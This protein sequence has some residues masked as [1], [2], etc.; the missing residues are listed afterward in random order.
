VVEEAWRALEADKPLYIAGGFGGAA[1]AVA[2]LLDGKGVPAALREDTWRV[3]AHFAQTAAALRDNPWRVELGLPGSMDAMAE[4]IVRLGASKLGAGDAAAVDWNGLT[5]A[6][7]R[8]LFS[9]RD[10]VTLAAL[11]LKGM[12][13]VARR[14]AAGRLQVELVHDSL[15]TADKLDAIAIATLDDVP[16]GGAG[17]AIDRLSGGTATAAR[18][19]GVSLVS[20]ADSSLDAGWLSM[21]S[22]GRLGEGPGLLERIEEAARETVAMAA[23]H[24]FMRVG[25]VSFGG[26]LI[27]DTAEV[28]RAMLRGFRSGGSWSPVVVWYENEDARFDSLLRVLEGEEAGVRLT[29]RRSPTRVLAEARSEEPLV[30]TVSLHGD[31]LSVTSLPPSAAATVS[32][33]T[34]QLT[35]AVLTQWGE[36]AGTARRRTPGQEVLRQRGEAMALR[37]LGPEAASILTRCQ[38]ARLTVVHD[39]PSARIPF[40]L[41]LAPPDHWPALGCGIT[42]RLSLPGLRYERQFVRAPKAGRLQVLVVV[43]PTEDLEGAEAEGRSVVEVLKQR[44]REVEVSVLRAREA[45][46]QA[47]AAALGKADILHYCGHAFFDGPGPGESGLMLAGGGPGEGVAFTAGALRG[48]EKLP[49]MAFVNACEAGRVRGRVVSE[50][51]AFAELFLSAGIDAYLGT[52]WEVGDAAAALFAGTVY[53]RLALGATLEAAVLEGRKALRTAQHADWANYMLFGGSD[54][55]IQLP[56]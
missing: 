3:H 25:V 8:A 33:Q 45:T 4:A 28:A 42:R 31:Q 7:N 19:R 39:V 46:P 24:G 2:D 11:V 18:A 43:N 50:A 5:M 30:L 29:T 36:G 52:Y 1:R 51:A 34:A 53:T 9:T 12:L 35:E 37:L 6:E 27:S 32:T 26:T 21:V 48:V 16:L 47:F 17:A 20:L 44:E 22:L 38:G 54:F 15:A 49:R 41:L 13:H 55:R 56:G 10:P 14:A 40:E 23:R